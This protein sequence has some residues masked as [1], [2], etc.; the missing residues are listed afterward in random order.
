[1]K[2]RL[3][4]IV[5]AC[6]IVAGMSAPVGAQE[7][8]LL[9]CNQVDIIEQTKCQIASAIL[10][11]NYDRMRKFINLGLVDVNDVTITPYGCRSFPECAAASA[12]DQTAL[13]IL[14]EYGLDPYLS[15]PAN[16]T[17]LILADFL[18]YDYGAPT[19]QTYLNHGLDINGKATDHSTVFEASM[20]WCAVPGANVPGS[21]HWKVFQ[22]ALAAQSNIETVIWYGQ[23]FAHYISSETQN[24]SACVDYLQAIAAKFGPR[25]TPLLSA[26]DDFGRVPSDYVSYYPNCSRTYP[27]TD[28]MQ[29]FYN[30]VINLGGAPFTI[31][32][33]ASAYCVRRSAGG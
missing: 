22:V 4:A 29:A 24:T 23:N 30:A 11:H 5:A 12:Q 9:A 26:K 21:A 3:S 14:F 25:L 33:G 17:R 15:Y 32:P 28:A 20:N 19:L 18:Y 10:T 6:C 27:F 8:R 31:V 13:A 1:M 7:N 2:W 16:P